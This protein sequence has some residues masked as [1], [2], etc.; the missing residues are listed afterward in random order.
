MPRRFFRPLRST[1]LLLCAVQGAEAIAATAQAESPAFEITLSPKVATE[2]LNG[3]LFVFLQPID[4]RPHGGH[5]SEPRFGPNWYDAEPFFGQDVLNFAPGQSHRID[6]TAD[7]FPDQLS[8]LAAGRYRAQAVLDINPDAQDPGRGAGNLYSAVVEIQFDPAAPS[9]V[10]LVLDRV[11]APETW[12]ESRWVEEVSLRSEWLSKFHH[13]DVFQQCGVV[14]PA[15]YYDQPQRHYPVV[16]MIPGFGSSHRDALQY[17][18]QPP[19]AADGEEEFIRVFLTGQCKWGHHVFVDSPT[20]GP[21]GEALILELIPEIDRRFRTVANRNGRFLYGHSSGGWSALWLMVNYPDVFGG[22]WSVSPDPVD[23]RDYQ[24][25]N[26]YADPPQNMYKDEAGNRRPIARN[27]DQVVLWYDSFTRMDDALKRGGQLR[28]FEAVFSP[29]GADGEPRKLY[30]RT[31]GMV[32]PDVARA[33]QAYD[34]HLQIEQHWQKLKPL[35]AGRMHIF[36]GD[37]DTY[38]LDGA[39]RKLAEGL[40]QLGSDAEVTLFAGRGHHDLLTPELYHTIRTQMSQLYR[41][42]NAGQ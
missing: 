32:D 6:D 11:V 34:I 10:P 31:T 9:T 33:W 17:A 42:E 37:H 25:V 2:P 3:R 1:L 7:S 27:G 8:H 30:D 13:R 26:L 24:G 28:S 18:D 21:R 20:N 12:P 16:Y 4:G 39:T 40:K 5:E 29:L 41:R 36:M 15:S 38:Y 35:L 23:F 19:P 22:V 14:L